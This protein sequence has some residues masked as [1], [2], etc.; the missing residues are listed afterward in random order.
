MSS[1]KI[2]VVS[3]GYGHQI[4][5]T[6]VYVDGKFAYQ[7]G[8]SVAVEQEHLDRLIKLIP[9]ENTETVSIYNKE[10]EE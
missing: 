3:E 5:R 2:K 7:S 6:I 8:N 9:M 1:I 10:E 4:G